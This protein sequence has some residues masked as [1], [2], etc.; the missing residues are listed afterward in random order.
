MTT[1][2]MQFAII[3]NEHAT[4]AAALHLASRHAATAMSI[5]DTVRDVLYTL[6][7]Y[8][9]GSHRSHAVTGTWSD[10]ASCRG[11]SVELL[12]LAG[13]LM[14]RIPETLG[15]Q[16]LPSEA[17][18]EYARMLDA[19]VSRADI[20]QPTVRTL[21]DRFGWEGAKAEGTHRSEIAR[22]LAAVRNVV[23]PAAFGPDVWTNELLARAATIR[24]IDG[25]RP[26]VVTGIETVPEVRALR[27]HGFTI[28]GLSERAGGIN[29]A[30]AGRD[31]VDIVIPA[32]DDPFALARAI[33]AAVT[34]SDRSP[35][36]AAA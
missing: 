35:L 20:G 1:H 24:A 33:D 14:E 4:H 12:R 30:A 10:L 29:T 2:T 11:L 7:P 26:L 28:V 18:L 3:G 17:A 5:T 36:G 8:L 27:R 13:T 22:L 31:L 34:A 32:T 15:R 25:P 16:S 9:A 23:V 19:W 21:I 6:D